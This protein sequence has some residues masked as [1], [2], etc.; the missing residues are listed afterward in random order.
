MVYSIHDSEKPNTLAPIIEMIYSMLYSENH[1]I[2]MQN[3]PSY[4][5]SPYTL[6][7]P[8]VQHTAYV[9]RLFLMTIPNPSML[10]VTEKTQNLGC[11][12]WP[13]YILGAIDY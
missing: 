6:M 2:G 3:T 1:N 13:P 12:Q 8:A 4:T 5:S 11:Y 9:H 10:N 7:R